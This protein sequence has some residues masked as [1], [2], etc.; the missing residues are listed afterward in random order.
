MFASEHTDPAPLDDDRIRW[1]IV[2]E[3]SFCTLP[4]Y[5]MRLDFVSGGPAGGLKPVYECHYAT[6]AAIEF[7]SE[8]EVANRKIA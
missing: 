7:R 1:L 4:S 8:T 3:R 6:V 2:S 5:L